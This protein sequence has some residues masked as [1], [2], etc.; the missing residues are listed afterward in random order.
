MIDLDIMRREISEVYNFTFS[1]YKLTPIMLA[2]AIGTYNI[3]KILLSS[4]LRE[5]I[6]A[7]DSQG[8]NCLYYAVYHGHL[9]IVKMLKDCNISYKKDAKGTTCLHIAISR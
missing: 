2:C 8:F 5:T 6:N 4:P 9:N 3:V 1:D 7:E